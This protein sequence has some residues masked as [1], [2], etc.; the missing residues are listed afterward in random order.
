MRRDK[1]EAL[2]ERLRQGSGRFDFDALLQG[3]ST[4]EEPAAEAGEKPAETG[5]SAQ[6]SEVTDAGPPT[7]GLEVPSSDAERLKTALQTLGTRLL[8][9]AGKLRAALHAYDTQDSGYYLARVNHVLELLLSVDPQGEVSRRFS[10]PMA[11]PAGRTWPNPCWTVYEM[12]E[13][14]LSG[15]L[16][17]DA[18]DEF[19]S[20]VMRVAVEVSE[21]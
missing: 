9:E 11:P 8:E 10:L 4:I 16:P 2:R 13:S 21:R 19:L 12:A 17:Q 6:T 20:G 5:E 7:I 3:V 18:D 1:T 15:L 14:P